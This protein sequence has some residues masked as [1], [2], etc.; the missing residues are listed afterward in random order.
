MNSTPEPTVVTVWHDGEVS[1]GTRALT[2]ALRYEDVEPFRVYL[3]D[4]EGRLVEARVS[5]KQGPWSEDE[6]AD[7][8]V[9]VRSATPGG[10]STR[11]HYS[12]DGRS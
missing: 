4:E 11:F 8:E 3:T 12:V 1:V 6:Y 9:T 10:P 5:Q 7:V 2:S